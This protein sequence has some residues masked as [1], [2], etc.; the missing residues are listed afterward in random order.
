M[1]WVRTE[2]SERRSQCRSRD[3]ERQKLA[4]Y[5]R[6]QY[7]VVVVVVV[8]VVIVVVVVVV[9]VLVCVCRRCRL[10]GLSPFAGDSDADT[11]VNV[12]A[13]EYDFKADEFKDVSETA[14][15]FIQKLLIQQPK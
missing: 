10:S 15:D 8:V 2:T 14:K 12:T 1:T 11:L 6:Y 9:V 7:V 13:A 4:R 3:L 5:S